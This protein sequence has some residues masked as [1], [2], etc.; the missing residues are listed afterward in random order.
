MI[1]R[2]FP[3]VLCSLVEV[4]RSLR[5]LGYDGVV[6]VCAVEVVEPGQYLPGDA[7]LLIDSEY[8]KYKTYSLKTASVYTTLYYIAINASLY[9]CNVKSKFL[10]PAIFSVKPLPRAAV[11]SNVLDTTTYL[12]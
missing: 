3:K 8:I 9:V 11:G 7:I 5:V 4:V 1:D 6:L 10:T 2:P 12:K